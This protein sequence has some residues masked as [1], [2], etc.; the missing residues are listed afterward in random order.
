MIADEGEYLG[1]APQNITTL[2]D[3]AD[4]ISRCGVKTMVAS[5][6]QYTWTGIQQGRR[7]WKCLDRILMNVAWQQQF[8]ALGLQHL[9]WT[10]LDHYPLLLGLVADGRVGSWPFKFQHMW[11]KHPA[12]LDVVEQSWIQPLEGYG[13]FLLAQKLKRLRKALNEWNRSTF[14]DIFANI[15]RAEDEVRHAELRLEE[16]ENEETRMHWS[17]AQAKLLKCLADE[18]TIWKQKAKVKWLKDG[19]ANTRFFHSKLLDKLAKLSIR[20]I[21][22]S[23]GSYIEDDQDIGAE[24]VSYFKRLMSSTPTSPEQAMGTLLQNIPSIVTQRQNDHLL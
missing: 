1:R 12:F 24:A 22:S 18:E 3:F 9:N 6:S 14:G 2:N 10:S 13:M 17:H 21:K 8:T 20:R 19:D 15:A 11:V 23:E 4:C 7:V 5:G 16:V